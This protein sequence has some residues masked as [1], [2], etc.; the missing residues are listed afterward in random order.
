MLEASRLHKENVDRLARSLKQLESLVSSSCKNDDVDYKF[1]A[2]IKEWRKSRA[3][4][5]DYDMVRLYPGIIL[6]YNFDLKL[7]RYIKESW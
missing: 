5:I 4:I 6:I 1:I 2:F 3:D 7:R